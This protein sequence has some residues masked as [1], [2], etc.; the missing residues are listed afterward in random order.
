[1][2]QS[3]L[4]ILVTAAAVSSLPSARGSCPTPEF[5]AGA[6]FP[7]GSGPNDIVVGD[8]NGDGKADLATADADT[9]SI[10]IPLGTGDGTFRAQRDIQRGGNAVA[11]ALGDVN[12]D[13]KLDLVEGDRAGGTSPA[14]AGVAVFPG[15]GGGTFQPHADYPVGPHPGWAAAGDVNGDGKPDI[16]CTNRGGD[17]VSVLLNAGNRAFAPKTDDAVGTNPSQV[18]L[19]DLNGDKKQDLVVSNE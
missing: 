13:G 6:A 11:I 18:A 1:M 2:R 19:A 17:S 14:F 10:S 9:S 8:L 15:K 12:R 4:Y 5:A 7:T 3:S 16:L